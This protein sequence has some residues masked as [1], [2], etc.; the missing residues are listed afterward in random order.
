M[1]AVLFIWANFRKYPFLL[2]GNVLLIVVASLIE[3]TSLIS[4]APIVDFFTKS[5]LQ[6]VSSITQKIVELGAHIGFPITL[7]T[8]IATFLILNI[9]SS[10]FQI[11]AVHMILRTK[12]TVLRDIIMGTFEDFFQARW[13]FFS[14]SGQGKLLNTFLREMTIV[15]DSFGAIARF[16]AAILQLLVYLSVPFYLSWQV[17]SIGLSATILFAAPF[18]FLGKI[19]YRLGKVSTATANQMGSV[20]KESF[21]LAKIILGFANQHKSSAALSHAFDTHREATLK[22]QTIQI[23]CP[24]TYYPLGLAVLLITLSAARWFGLSL[25]EMSVF[26]YAMVRAIPTV[27]KITGEKIL[28]DNFF[29]SYEQVMSLRDRAGKLRQRTGTKIFTEFDKEI[30]L[31]GLSFAYPGHKP[32]LIDID[33]RIPRGKM[34]AFVGE[35]GAGKSTLVDTIMGFNEI[36]TGQIIIDGIPLQEFDIKSYRKRL[37]YVP[38]DSILFNM[39]IMDNMRWADENATD[40]QIKRACVQANADEFIERFP[41]GYQTL[42]GDRGVRLSGGQIQRIALARAILRKPGILILDEAT[43]SLDSHSERLIQQAV[44]NIA[45]ETTVI[46]VAHRL[47]T[48]TSADYVYV[49]RRGRVVEEGSYSQLALTNGYFSKMVQLQELEARSINEETYKNCAADPV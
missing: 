27:G 20:V 45:R 7:G 8:M 23:A 48:I 41:D 26:V 11:F 35:S 30:A 17:V 31:K 42:V 14:S 18:I 39:T 1:K 29:P 37:G 5:D 9:L 21:S 12:Y 2:I 32:I 19:T 28:M 47:S 24:L 10:G 46:V 13:Y 34:I 4:I 6:N 49:L 16:F 40:E 38:Q 44:N 22:A 25:S 33:V 36:L 15:G 43:S 3:A